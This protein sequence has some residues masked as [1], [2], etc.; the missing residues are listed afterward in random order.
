M[1]LA[2]VGSCWDLMGGRRVDSFYDQ[3]TAIYTHLPPHLPPLFTPHL[4]IYARY[5]LDPLVQ[6]PFSNSSRSPTLENAWDKT[7]PAM[8]V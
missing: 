8:R 5:P 6:Q 1:F 7:G 2:A 3:E 4:S